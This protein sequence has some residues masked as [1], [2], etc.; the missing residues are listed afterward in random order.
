MGIGMSI[1]IRVSG[2]QVS[3]SR[4]QVSGIRYQVL[5]GNQ[6]RHQRR[7]EKGVGDGTDGDERHRAVR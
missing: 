3:S 2:C 1:G 4:Y 7:R 6:G 5:V